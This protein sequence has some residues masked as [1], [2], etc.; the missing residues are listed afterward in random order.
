[1]GVVTYLPIQAGEGMTTI[2]E[3]ASAIAAADLAPAPIK[4]SELSLENKARYVNLAN[5]AVA[6]CA[7]GPELCRSVSAFSGPY[8]F[9]ATRAIDVRL[10][11]LS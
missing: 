4:W 2:E 8:K 3:M 6:D 7:F 11:D 1:M 9:M 5:A 10:N